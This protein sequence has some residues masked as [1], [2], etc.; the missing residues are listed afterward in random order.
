MKN[1]FD[2]VTLLVLFVTVIAACA[3]PSTMP[4]EPAEDYSLVMFGEQ[5]SSLEGTMGAQPANH[6]VDGRTGRA[7][8]PDSL[9][10]TPQQIAAIKVLRD[11]FK[12]ANKA[13]LD[14]LRDIFS[15]ARDARRS[16][17]TREEIHAILVTSRPIVQALRP[18]VLQLHVAIRAVFTPAQRAWLDAHRP[19]PPVTCMACAPVCNSGC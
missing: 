12:E 15:R 5:G 1:L 16:G 18:A 14:S 10:L 19:R 4:I 2:A 17:A 9:K 3:P 7:Q 13:R 11:N 8:L 6:P